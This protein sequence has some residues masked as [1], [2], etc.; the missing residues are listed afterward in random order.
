MFSIHSLLDLIDWTIFH[1]RNN[2]PSGH[3]YSMFWCVKYKN[4]ADASRSESII[5][6]V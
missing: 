3:Q 4:D 6:F 1:G 2:L 5:T